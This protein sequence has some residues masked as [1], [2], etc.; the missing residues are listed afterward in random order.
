[1]QVY[2]ERTTLITLAKIIDNLAT[3]C[4]RTYELKVFTDGRHLLTITWSVPDE[5]E[6]VYEIVKLAVKRLMHFSVKIYEVDIPAMQI[7][8]SIASDLPDMFQ[9]IRTSLGLRYDRELA[10]AFG[11]STSYISR[12]KSGASRLY[13][14]TAQQMIKTAELDQAHPELAKKLLAM[15]VERK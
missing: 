1:M 7:F 12:L 2:I 5:N 3:E 10:Q 9:T 8:D 15:S 14:T 13:T 6:K 11:I 4:S